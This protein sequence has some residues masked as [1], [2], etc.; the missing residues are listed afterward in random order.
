MFLLTH[1][2]NKVIPIL[3]EEFLNTWHGRE[4]SGKGQSGAEADCRGLAT[5]VLGASPSCLQ[6]SLSQGNIERPAFTL[7]YGQVKVPNSPHV[8]C[9]WAVGGRR[10]FCFFFSVIKK[11]H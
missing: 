5:G 4:Q 11:F 6:A 9:Y 1:S 3:T 10:G 7:T 2:V 8:Q